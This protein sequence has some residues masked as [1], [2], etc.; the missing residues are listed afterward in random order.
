MKHIDKL[1]LNQEISQSTNVTSCMYYTL[2][3][4]RMY[5]S[6]RFKSL[7]ILHMHI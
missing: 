3:T 2:I 6:I 5:R 1:I 4:G 7:K